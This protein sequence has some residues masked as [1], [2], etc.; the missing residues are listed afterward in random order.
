MRG[1]LA[2]MMCLKERSI[3]KI[4]EATHEGA[5]EA[6]EINTVSHFFSEDVGRICLAGD[7]LSRNGPVLNL[8]T[9]RIFTQFDVSSRLRGHVVGP[10]NTGFIVIVDK[11]R[12]I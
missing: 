5:T 4:R 10:L 11:S 6:T 12:L 9:D 3:K 2:R 7:V 8:F 1:T